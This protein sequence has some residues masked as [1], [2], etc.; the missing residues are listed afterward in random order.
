[1]S[2]GVERRE[3]TVTPH[4]RMESTYGGLCSRCGSNSATRTYYSDVTIHGQHRALIL[5]TCEHCDTS[6]EPLQ[7]NVTGT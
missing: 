7:D 2:G 4:S 3:I 5:D 6:R 1:M